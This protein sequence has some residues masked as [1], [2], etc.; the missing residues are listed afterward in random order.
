MPVAG[1]DISAATDS[2]TH[3]DLAPLECQKHACAIQTCIAKYNHA[4][5]PVQHCQPYFN[6]YKQCISIRKGTADNTRLQ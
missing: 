1:G 5:D 6:Y 3:D 4:P 2:K